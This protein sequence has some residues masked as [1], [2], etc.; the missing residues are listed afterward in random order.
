MSLFRASL[1]SIFLF[2]SITSYT[3]VLLYETNFDSPAYVPGDINGQ[4][5][6]IRQFGEWNITTMNPVS[7]DQNL[8]LVE[9]GFGFSRCFSPLLPPMAFASGFATVM[10]MMSVDGPGGEI[11]FVPQN[12]AFGFV[13]TRILFN[14]DGSIYALD[15]TM[16]VS[17]EPTGANYPSG[18]FLVTVIVDRATFD[19]DLFIDQDLI[20]EGEGFAPDIEQ[21]VFEAGNTGATG[22]V[23]IDDLMIY[24]GE[25]IPSSPVEIVPTLGEWS[26][27]SLALIFMIFGVV[28]IRQS[29]FEINFG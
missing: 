9:N 11:Q 13:N 5:G 3:Q 8:R 22:V 26:V 20:F 23:D 7:G 27:I 16:G 4:N 6:W 29:A 15:N 17:L 14:P 28:S 1:A 24:D 12:P 2:L 19:F 10:V 25:V 21:I 18:Y